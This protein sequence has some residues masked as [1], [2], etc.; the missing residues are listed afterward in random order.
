MGIGELWFEMSF[1]HGRGELR[2][3]R[4][5]ASGDSRAQSMVGVDVRKLKEAGGEGNWRGYALA[6]W[7]ALRTWWRQWSPEMKK[8]T[9]S[10]RLAVP[11]GS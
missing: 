11:D 3:K 1:L 9:I 10:G 8:E 5:F 6:R 4:G 7:K 2:W